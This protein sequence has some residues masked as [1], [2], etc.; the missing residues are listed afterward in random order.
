MSKK[1]KDKHGSAPDATEQSWRFEVAQYRTD[2]HNPFWKVIQ[3]LCWLLAFLALAIIAYTAWFFF[4]Q[5]ANIVLISILSILSGSIIGYFRYLLW[6]QI[7]KHVKATL[8]GE[9][10]VEVELY[11][12][13][14][15]DSRSGQMMTMHKWKEGVPDPQA[16]G[17]GLD[18][19]MTNDA[20]AIQSIL[21]RLCDLQN[22]EIG[23]QGIL[24]ISR[25]QDQNN[26]KTTWEF[27]CSHIPI[28]RLGLE[29]Q[30]IVSFF[31][32]LFLLASAAYFGVSQNTQISEYFM[33]FIAT[34]FAIFTLLGLRARRYLK[35]SSQLSFIIKDHPTLPDIVVA[36]W[37]KCL[38]PLHHI[39]KSWAILSN[40]Q[41]VKDFCESVHE[42]QEI[43]QD[44]KIDHFRPEQEENSD[45]TT[46]AQLNAD[47]YSKFLKPKLG[48]SLL[49]SRIQKQ[50][51]HNQ[52]AW[53]IVHSS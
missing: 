44:A 47:S 11:G 42:L 27:A 7:T 48:L 33:S 24:R 10:Y 46:A 52:I 25:S 18:P 39:H 30:K 15:G 45:T 9:F 8:Q 5:G 1:A 38:G 31:M 32:I 43:I 17:D 14:Y 40:A 49:Q 26:N 36:E 51:K 20:V 23:G 12:K 22:Q 13:N 37:T 50:K 19:F 41:R 4:R 3:F 2:F 28:Q 16:D 34:A 53:R 21:P 6:V 29:V 35:R